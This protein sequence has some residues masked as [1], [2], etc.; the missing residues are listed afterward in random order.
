MKNQLIK[1]QVNFYFDTKSEE[2][3]QKLITSLKNEVKNMRAIN[4]PNVV[5]LYD[6]KKS[7]NN[8]YLICEYCNNGNL[9]NYLLS[10][11]NKLSLLESIKIM[12]D[13]EREKNT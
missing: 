4:H 12:K 9:E 3:I 7:S 1:I 10:R 6:V 13:R 11:Q 5:K 2:K 8:F